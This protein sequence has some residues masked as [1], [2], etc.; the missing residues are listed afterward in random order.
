[1][2]NLDDFKN[3]NTKFTGT[4]GE[5]VSPGTTLERVDTTGVLRFNTTNNLMEYYDGTTWKSIDAPPTLSSISPTSFA[6]DGSTLVDIDITGSGFSTSVTALWIGDDGTEYT[7]S[8]VTRNS[9]T[10]VTVRTVATMGVANEPYDIKITNSS[11]LAA[12][13]ADALDAGA[14]PAFSAAAGSLGTLPNG[15]RA[16]SNLTSQT[17]GPD[18]DADSQTITYTVTSGS[19][20]AG[21]SLGTGANNGTIQGTADAV[22][23]NTTSSFTIQ[24]SDGIN[25]NSRAYTITVNAPVVESFTSSGT[26]SVPAG[27]S[28]VDVLVVAGGG[29]GAGGG[30]G[31]GAGG[32][33]GAGGLIFMPGAP[34]TPGGS[35]PITVG[36]GGAAAGGPFSGVGDGRGSPGG[37]SIFNSPTGVLTAIGGGTGGGGNN[38]SGPGLPGGS[39]GGAGGP[40]GGPQNGGTATQPTQPGNSS[41]YGFGNPGGTATAPTAGGG[42][43]GGAGSA[44]RGVGTPDPVGGTGG[45][46]RSY[47]ISGSSITYAGGG[48][49]GAHVP[50]GVVPGSGGPGGGGT[51]GTGAGPGSTPG[52]TN[53]GAGGGGGG[54]N[55]SP[56]GPA[57][58]GGPGIVIVKY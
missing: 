8:V 24:A 5:R 39:G 47:D 57:G 22:G 40:G 18:Q 38:P 37:N 13:L 3:K 48:G 1:M 51:G 31:Y 50:Q 23:T 19:L 15:A 56:S 33:G 41:T 4:A 28:S 30:G 42:G 7:P 11:G 12:T 27:V 35:V 44:G 58:S 29:A 54:E 16:S 17:F 36:N 43:G 20:P 25:T 14:T 2:S 21:L 52:A 53:R 6:S 34:V 45:S 55:P 46:G 10:S 32:G 26:F 9:S 49:G